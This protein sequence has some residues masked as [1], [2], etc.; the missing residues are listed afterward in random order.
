MKKKSIP[1]AVMMLCASQFAFA[2]SGDAAAPQ[3]IDPAASGA[4]GEDVQKVVIVSTGSRGS[5]RSMIDTPVP[6]DILGSRELTKTG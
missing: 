5:Q 4:A 2:Q 6:V 3:S 1:L